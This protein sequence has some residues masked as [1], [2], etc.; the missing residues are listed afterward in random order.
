[1]EETL[2]V[3]RPLSE[4]RQNLILSIFSSYFDNVGAFVHNF[5]QYRLSK[6]VHRV[7]H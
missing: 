5:P 2:N 4:M 1:M 3:K 6:G 7:S